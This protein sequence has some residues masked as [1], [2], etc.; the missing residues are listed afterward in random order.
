MI[1]VITPTAK[2][3]FKSFSSMLAACG[4]AAALTLHRELL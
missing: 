1:L 3:E 2:R 4:T